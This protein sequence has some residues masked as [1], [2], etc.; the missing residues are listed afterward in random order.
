MKIL[1]I[2]PPFEDFYA[3]PIR[4]YPLGILYAAGALK[5]AGCE[6]AVLD[7]LRPLTKRHRPVP[8]EMDYLSPYLDHPL[9]FKG[10][11]RFG[12]GENDIVR[13]I[14]D[15]GPD[16]VGISSQF[17]AYFQ[18][19]AELAKVIKKEYGLPIFVG[20]HHATAFPAEIRQKS[21]EIDF[22]LQG[23]A[24]QCLPV[25]LAQQGIATGPAALDWSEVQPSRELLAGGHYRIGRKNYM[26]L[27]ASRGCPFRC[28]FCSVGRMFGRKITYRPLEN[29]L[30]DMR[31]GYLRDDVR[32]FNFED[33]N[34][35][36]DRAW[37]TEF[38][39][40]VAAD[41]VLRGTEL[42]AMNGLC[43]QTLDEDLLEPMWK[44][45][46]RQLNLSLVTL[47]PEVKAGY[48]RLAENKDFE[49]LIRAAKKLGFFVTVYV[50]IGL[51]GQSA[52]EIRESMDYLWKLG[53][54]VGP[55][56][57]YLPPAS[58]LFERLEIDPYL[59]GTW[60]LY[61]SSAFAVETAALSRRRL[62]DLFLYARQKNLEMKK[63]IL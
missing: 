9:F 6:V 43:S 20:G 35:S 8:D 12:L 40:A 16:F 46:F 48:H 3:T 59:R 26:S 47:D 52:E 45:G 50:I 25:F 11:Y 7:C 58:P 36:F 1:L 10:Y 33:D 2:Q 41:P 18:S 31:L 49:D 15:F 19:I 37:F 38:L 17:T 56:V 29:V 62:I 44:A 55:S 51:P 4:L 61:R 24:E 22:V 30:A 42:T 57:F 27:V 32:I 39:R 60:N 23:P 34:L 13:K 5:A 28:D 54:L 14:K 21:P 53:A 63:K